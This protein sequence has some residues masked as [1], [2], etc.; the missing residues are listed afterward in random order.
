MIFEKVEMSCEDIKFRNALKSL[1]DKAIL[2]YSHNIRNE[3][4][5]NNTNKTLKMFIYSIFM[6]INIIFS[7]Y[8]CLNCYDCF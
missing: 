3:T 2:V 1:Q 8:T 6:T 5:S 7:S 4:L